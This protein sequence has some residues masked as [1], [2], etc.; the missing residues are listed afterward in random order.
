MT[1]KIAVVGGTGDLGLGLASRLARSYEV[2]IGSRDAS[3]AAEAASKASAL[4]GVAVT[5]TTN[6]QATALADV[7]ILAIP[8]LPSDE[9]LLSLKPNLAG[10][11]VISPIV[12]MEFRDG[13]F[14]PMLASGSAAEKVASILQTRVAGA[15]H[16]VPA[17]RL[18][19]VD[20]VLDYDVL[21]AAETKDVFAEASEIISSIARLRPLYAGPLRS[22]RTMEL[23]TPTLLNVGKLN[24]LRTPSVKVV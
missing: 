13:L 12:P 9:A 6:A 8:D 10:K 24:K 2:I 23:L 21:V 14:F 3:R 20:K 5:G 4:S 18:M 15:F 1:K 7:A 19:E 11:L 22:S 17:A 16:N